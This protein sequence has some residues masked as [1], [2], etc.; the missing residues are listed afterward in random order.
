[1]MRQNSLKFY[2][3]HV[4]KH[5]NNQKKIDL[6]KYNKRADFEQVIVLNLDLAQ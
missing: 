4:I 2:R 3:N 6:E 1:M 5:I